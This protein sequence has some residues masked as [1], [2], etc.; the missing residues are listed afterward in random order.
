MKYLALK[1]GLQEEIVLQLDSLHDR[2]PNEAAVYYEFA[3]FYKNVNE[4]EKSYNI[5]V[6]GTKKCRSEYFHEQ[7]IKYFEQ[8]EQYRLLKNEYFRL[9]GYYPKKQKYYYKAIKYFTARE[10][11]KN[12]IKVL[13]QL[14]KVFPDKLD[15][16]YYYKNIKQY[17]R[18]IKEF[19]RISIRFED[20][21][22]AGQNHYTKIQLINIYS[23]LSDL[24]VKLEK[25]D[26]AYLTF[27]KLIDLDHDNITHIIQKARILENQGQSKESTELLKKSIQKFRQLERKDKYKYSSK[28]I[29]LHREFIRYFIEKG[30]FKTALQFYKEMLEITPL[31]ET[32]AHE[33]FLYSQKQNLYDNLFNH[34]K[35]VQEKV[36]RDYRYAYLCYYLKFLEKDYSVSAEYIEKAIFLEPA[37]IDLNYKLVDLYKAQN[38]YQKA[39]TALE[40][41][42]KIYPTYNV[43]QYEELGMLYFQIGNEDMAIKSW[44]KMIKVFGSKR[45]NYYYSIKVFKILLKYKLY[46]PAEVVLKK[47]QNDSTKNWEKKKIETEFLKLY[48]LTGRYEKALDSAIS[49]FKNQYIYSSYYSYKKKQVIELFDYVDSLSLIKREYI[50]L[51]SLKLPRHEPM[52][53]MLADMYIRHGDIWK[54]IELLKKVGKHDIE[55][56]RKMFERELYEE[57]LKE[58]GDLKLNDLF[59]ARV[60]IKLKKYEAARI[61]LEKS[62]H[63]YPILYGEIL[64]EL[65]MIQE[66]IKYGSEILERLPLRDDDYIEFSEYLFK[67]GLKEEAIKYFDFALYLKNDFNNQLRKAKFLYKLGDEIEAIEYLNSLKEKKNRHTSSLINI[68]KTFNEIDHPEIGIDILSSIIDEIIKVNDPYNWQMMDVNYFI[69]NNYH[70]EF[71]NQKIEIFE[72]ISNNFPKQNNF[73]KDVV[74]LYWKAEQYKELINFVSRKR[75][76]QNDILRNNYLLKLYILSLIKIQDFDEAEIEIKKLVNSRNLTKLEI[77]YET[78]INFNYAQGDFEACKRNLKKYYGLNPNYPSHIRKTAEFAEEF[79]FPELAIQYRYNYYKMNPDSTTEALKLVSLLNENNKHKEAKDIYT[80]LLTAATKRDKKDQILIGFS[81][82]KLNTILDELTEQF[83]QLIEDNPDE[84]KYIIILIK[85]AEFIE[86]DE[87]FN[88]MK[89]QAEFI[90]PFNFT[91]LQFEYEYFKSINDQDNLVKCKK[92]MLSASPVKCRKYF[93][94][95]EK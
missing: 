39:I 29:S 93:K 56:Y 20:K 40:K 15:L 16:A 46:K 18:A 38:E 83:K 67:I 50:H 12:R 41:I 72:K 7:V 3:L 73:L 33:V 27:D 66:A 94:N 64:A 23:H 65:G 87:L 82:F 80:E 37:R 84:L 90:N 36:S 1:K 30:K 9:I 28:R 79:S 32:L 89:K 8:E 17:K 68:A 10:D 49:D 86:D 24:Y 13:K 70:A 43:Q 6:R 57:I 52:L 63:S 45:S 69:E 31:D 11:E 55:I 26:K 22:K 14:I 47:M 91:L 60:E 61:R 88:E 85:T 95:E 78:L 21:L 76:E 62:A 42:I 19:E 34:F 81:S 92:T 48:M 2:N 4:S 25:F 53:L 74:N 5:L 44:K 77:G 59:L 35:G 75:I 71:I 58:E 54:G 51:E